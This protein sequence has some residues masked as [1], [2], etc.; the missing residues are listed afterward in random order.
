[1]T[2]VL[3]FRTHT[4]EH[5]YTPP[6][7]RSENDSTELEIATQPRLQDII[8]LNQGRGWFISSLIQR[9]WLEHYTS[10]SRLDYDF[11]PIRGYVENVAPIDLIS[12]SPD[13]LFKLSFDE[14][15]ERLRGLLQKIQGGLIPASEIDRHT[16]ELAKQFTR[17]IYSIIVKNELTWE[18]PHV[19]TDGEGEVSLEWW[20]RRKALTIFIDPSGQIEYLKAWGPHIWR[21]MEDGTNPADEELLNLWRWLF[22]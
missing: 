8:K 16:V 19:A 2:R 17:R 1:M 6:V 14:F 20:H 9:G 12:N 22:T 15:S 4:D 10:A 21:E 13:E 3:D 11:E 5:Y 7:K 18:T